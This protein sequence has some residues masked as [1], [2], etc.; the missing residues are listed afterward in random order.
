MANPF[1]P[2]NYE[3]PNPSTGF[4][5]FEEGQT[6]FRVLSSPLL[7]W[8]S[9]TDAAGGKRTVKR[10]SYGEEHPPTAKHFWAMVVWNYGEKRIQILNITQATIQR[11]LKA[12]A[13]NSD[14]GS[15]LEYDITVSRIGKTMNDTKYT[16]IPSPAKP[17]DP[18]IAKK[19]VS[20][21]V[22]MEKYLKGED[23]FEGADKPMTLDDIPD[24]PT[25]EENMPWDAQ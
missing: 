24:Q 7:G 23:P 8:E 3:V 18:E 12:L 21:K 2:D 15:P 16:L 6:K 13:S 20:A 9:W 4:L 19:F 5:K 25:A 1:L 10:Y 22:N 11:Q 17:I 14:W